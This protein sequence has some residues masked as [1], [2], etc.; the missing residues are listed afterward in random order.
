MDWGKKWRHRQKEEER[1][2]VCRALG[3]DP[4]TVVWPPEQADGE[5]VGFEAELPAATE[6][7]HLSDEDWAILAPFL[8]REVSAGR[9]H[10]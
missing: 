4:G 7:F 3:I 2:S 9:R 6:G 5:A 8:P 10:E 1:T